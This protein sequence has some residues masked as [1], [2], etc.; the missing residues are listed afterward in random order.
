MCDTIIHNA[1]LTNMFYIMLTMHCSRPMS[2]G[3]L[4]VCLLYVVVKIL[5]FFPLAPALLYLWT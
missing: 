4:S 2:V 1:E 3:V 5:P